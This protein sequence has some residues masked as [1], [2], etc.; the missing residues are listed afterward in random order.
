[1]KIITI[2]IQTETS[3]GNFSVLPRV[4]EKLLK[5]NINILEIIARNTYPQL[6]S[7]TFVPKVKTELS[8]TIL[9]KRFFDKFL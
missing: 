3:N 2:G 6:F 5:K 4:A 1:M 7:L 9:S 8:N